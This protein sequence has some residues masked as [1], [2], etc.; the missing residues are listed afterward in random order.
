VAYRTA[1]KPKLDEQ[2]VGTEMLYII[3]IRLPVVLVAYLLELVDPDQVFARQ[4]ECLGCQSDKWKK[5]K[6]KKLEAIYVAENSL[7]EVNISAA[8]RKGRGPGRV[9]GPEAVHP[10]QRGLLRGG[11]YAFVGNLG[12]STPSWCSVPLLCQAIFPPLL[13]QALV[14]AHQR[15][16]LFGFLQASHVNTD[17][18]P[19][20]S[21][22]VGYLLSSSTD[23][24]PQTLGVTSAGLPSP[25]P[26][27]RW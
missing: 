20:V 17:A 16:Q 24:H 2:R 27:C 21:S 25:S 22:D 4:A 10:F 14:H 13:L 23:S 7:L 18:P 12:G 8:Q 1:I 5:K 6:A 9:L 15:G 3:S 19:D 11:A 26:R